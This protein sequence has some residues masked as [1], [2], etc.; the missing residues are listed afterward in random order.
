MLVSLYYSILK[1]HVIPKGLTLFLKNREEAEKLS[2]DQFVNEKSII[3]S[4]QF[5]RYRKMLA[6]STINIYRYE[7]VIYAKEK[8]LADV[9]RHLGLSTVPEVIGSIAN[10]F[11]VM[12]ASEDQD[13]H[14]RQ[15]HPGD[16]KNK[17]RQ[18]TIQELNTSL[19]DFL[20]YFDYEP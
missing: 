14:I 6:G 10:Q 2:I 18:Q 17:L 15:V 20:R 8:W 3:F 16:H 19:A 1:S 13:S 5:Q 9:V 7:D 12:P 4:N 11:D